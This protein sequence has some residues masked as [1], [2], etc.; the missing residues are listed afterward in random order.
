[1]ERTT[2]AEVK[3]MLCALVSD[4]YDVVLVNDAWRIE[5]KGRVPQFARVLY[6]ALPGYQNGQP[7]TAPP[8][9]TG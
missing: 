5:I 8:A 2:Q 7:Q 1:M 3:L 4:G 9:K 6:P